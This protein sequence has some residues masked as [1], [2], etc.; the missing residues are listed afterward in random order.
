M[1]VA[2]R[3]N[4]VLTCGRAITFLVHGHGVEIAAKS[5]AK[6]TVVHHAARRF[7]NGGSTQLLRTTKAL[8]SEDE[9]GTTKH[10]STNKITVRTIIFSCAGRN[11]TDAGR[12]VR[13]PCLDATAVPSHATKQQGSRFGCLRLRAARQRAANAPASLRRTSDPDL[14]QLRRYHFPS[15][16]LFC[17]SHGAMP[18]AAE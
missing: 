9:A 17:R 12:Y 13:W 11:R 1:M 10:I 4:S 7:C 6:L 18:K 16:C 2:R 8:G 5:A 15:P 14:A 3:R